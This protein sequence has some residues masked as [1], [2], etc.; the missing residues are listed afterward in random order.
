VVISK[1]NWKGSKRRKRD[2]LQKRMDDLSDLDGKESI[3]RPLFHKLLTLIEPRIF[4]TA[5]GE[6]FAEITYGS[7]VI[8]PT[9]MLAITLLAGGSYLNYLINHFLHLLPRRSQKTEEQ[10]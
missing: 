2:D 1:S 9:I 7:V 4:N 6:K 5:E 10:Y 8:T 3:A